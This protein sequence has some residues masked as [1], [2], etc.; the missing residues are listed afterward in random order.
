MPVVVTVEALMDVVPDTDKV[1]SPETVS[2][3]MAFPLMVSESLLLSDTVDPKITVEPV[4]IE[5]AP[6]VTAPE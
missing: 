6:K 4:S 5:F 2:L 3:K 1:V